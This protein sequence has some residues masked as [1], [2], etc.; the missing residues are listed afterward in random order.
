MAPDKRLLLRLDRE[1]YTKIKRWAAADL[2]SVNRQ[3]EYIL[4]RGW[5]EWGDE[6]STK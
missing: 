5:E 2:R 4:R 6:Y 3:I 1:L